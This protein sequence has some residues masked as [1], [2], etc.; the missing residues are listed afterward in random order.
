MKKKWRRQSQKSIKP[1]ACSLRRLKKFDKSSAKLRKKSQP[2]KI[3]NEKEEIKTDNTEI[4]CFIRDYY[5]EL[6]AI[7]MHNF[8]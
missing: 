4:P 1:K 5:K 7:K 6:C 8:E 2:N 3:R